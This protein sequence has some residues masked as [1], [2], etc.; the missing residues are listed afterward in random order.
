MLMVTIRLK[1]EELKQTFHADTSK[2]DV[3]TIKRNWKR[4]PHV[5]G[6]EMV[7]W[8]DI[9]KEILSTRLS[10]EVYSGLIG[11]MQTF[12]S[13]VPNK[14]IENALVNGQNDH[15]INI[16][17]GVA[18]IVSF[19]LFFRHIYTEPQRIFKEHVENSD[20]SSDFE[21]K[22]SLLTA[23]GIR[24]C[25]INKM[26]QICKQKTFSQFLSSISSF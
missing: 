3:C 7:N 12:H 16:N 6:L 24:R 17:V 13:N 25:K 26:H 2:V 22:I 5:E 10:E 9:L 21:V 15:F 18:N 23:F 20:E 8:A 1:A 11:V 19:P 14:Q 4:H